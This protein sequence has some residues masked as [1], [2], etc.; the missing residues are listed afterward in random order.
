MSDGQGLFSSSWFFEREIEE[1]ILTEDGEVTSKG[2]DSSFDKGLV[3]RML[4]NV[5]VNRKSRENGNCVEQIPVHLE[6]SHLGR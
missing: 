3:K 1:I 2:G 4:H 6:V 5:L